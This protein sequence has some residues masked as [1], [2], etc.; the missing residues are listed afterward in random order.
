MFSMMLVIDRERKQTDA[1]L[2]N[3]KRSPKET[4]SI[5]LQDFLRI[6]GIVAPPSSEN[7]ILELS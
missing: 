2:S 1:K 7:E 5:Q 6:S 3:T 4:E